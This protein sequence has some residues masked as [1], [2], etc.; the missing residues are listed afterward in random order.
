VVTV[1]RR[2]VPGAAV[3]VEKLRYR[4]HGHGGIN[5]ADIEHLHVTFRARR[6]SLTRR[7]RALARQTGTLPHGLYLMGT[8]DHFCTP[9]ESWRWAKTAAGETCAER[10][11]AMAAGMTDPGWRVR[12]R[13]SFHV[14][15][16]RWIPPKRRGRPSRALQGLVARWCS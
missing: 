2:I 9:P 1:E 7:G 14:P 15:S 3:R 13:L 11:P 8:V 10:T 16:P 6:S 12:A 4:S 5:T